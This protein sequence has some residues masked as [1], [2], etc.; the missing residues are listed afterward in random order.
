MK[1]NL[2]YPIRQKRTKLS[3]SEDDRGTLFRHS[4]RGIALVIALGAMLMIL[5][6]GALSVYLISRG[7]SV[8]RGQKQYQSAFEAC[9]GGIEI[10]IGKVDS[11]FTNS[12]DPI[13]DT[14]NV[15][16]FSVRVITEPIMATTSAGSAIKFARGYFGVGQGISQGGVNLFYL[17]QAQSIGGGGEG[18]TIEIEQKKT[19]GI[20]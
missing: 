12:V 3:R 8:A 2:K 19:L 5:I 1:K 9:E 20:D 4:Q 13:S 7:L 16:H 18:V 6:V 15:G 14:L 10:G 11:A 17:V